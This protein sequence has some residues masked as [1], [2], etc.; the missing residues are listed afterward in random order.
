[1]TAFYEAGERSDPS[2]HA[3]LST[4]VPNGPEL[5][6]ETSFLEAQV[7]SGVVGPTTWRLGNEHVVSINGGEATV[8]GCSYD[9]GAR[10]ASSG[11]AAPSDLGGGAGYTGYVSTLQLHGAEWLLYSTTVSFPTNTKQA[12]P[13][14]GF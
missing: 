8:S 9:P 13:C 3:L 4:L 1:M 11:A 10:Y 6:L 12:G 7:A 5:K 14:L 2:S